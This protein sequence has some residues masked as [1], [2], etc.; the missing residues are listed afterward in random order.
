[1][2][3]FPLSQS[4]AR[5]KRRDVECKRRKLAEMLADPNHPKHGTSTGYGYGCRCERCRA[6]KREWRER[7]YLPR[8]DRR[9]GMTLTLLGREMTV[10]EVADATG[11][12]RR[13]IRQA[14]RAIGKEACARWV[15]GE[16]AKGA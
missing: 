14:I 8:I 7:E 16:M 10:S 3:G 13:K 4:P 6:A 1:M 9:D 15:Y 11:I 5:R 12:P 2:S